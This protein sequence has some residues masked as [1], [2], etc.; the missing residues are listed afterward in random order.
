MKNNQLD[1]LY[2]TFIKFKKS[3]ETH[4]LSDIKTRNSNIK[5]ERQNKFYKQN[6][7]YPNRSYDLRLSEQKKRGR[8]KKSSSPGLVNVI[9][10]GSSKSSIPNLNLQNSAYNIIKSPLDKVKNFDKNIG[11][12]SLFLKMKQ[13]NKEKLNK[14]SNQG[15]EKNGNRNFRT[16]KR[17]VTA[18]RQQILNKIDISKQIL[19]S[20]P[21]LKKSRVFEELEEKGNLNGRN[22]SEKSVE[23]QNPR[24][25]NNEIKLM[26]IRVKKMD[27]QNDL[28]FF[29]NERRFDNSN[30]ERS[31]PITTNPNDFIRWR[32]KISKRKS[33]KLIDKRLKSWSIEVSSIDSSGLDPFKF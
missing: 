29:L 15:E 24:Y 10:I 19:A 20:E 31:K 8:R 25:F 27:N 6:R 5:K 7:Y 13:R 18:K 26:P 22:K 9:N 28:N 14:S 2:K 23:I 30:N 1:E 21:A 32:P 16:S 17:K 11:R 4:I 12:D 33:F 3:Q